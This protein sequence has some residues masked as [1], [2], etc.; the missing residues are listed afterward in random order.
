MLV[1]GIETSCDETGVALYDTARAGDTLLPSLR[2][3]NSPPLSWSPPPRSW[4]TWTSPRACACLRA[5]RCRASPSPRT[6]RRSPATT[7][8][9][10]ARLARALA[11]A[12]R[13]SSA[14]RTWSGSR[15]R[16]RSRL[17][18][19]AGCRSRSRIRRRRLG[20]RSW[21]LGGWLCARWRAWRPRGGR[22]LGAREGRRDEGGGVV[23]ATAARA[24]TPPSPPSPPPSSYDP[25]A[26]VLLYTPAGSPRPPAHLHPAT[27]RAADASAAAID[28]W[29]G[30]P[31]TAA[32]PVPD[33]LRP[34]SVA[35]VG[36][37]AAQISW[38][39]GFNQVGTKASGGVG[40]GGAAPVCAAAG[41][42][43]AL[44]LP[45]S[46]RSSSWTRSRLPQ[47]RARR[48]LRGKGVVGRPAQGPRPLQGVADGA[49]APAGG[50]RR[51]T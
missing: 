42:R 16:P 38:E 47:R 45:R 24:L 6:W 40:W 22:A 28:E 5:L 17:R 30:A 10:T 9:C 7:A 51:A 15:S 19:T 39:D 33:D 43:R 20:T 35:A 37:Y 31:A 14:S 21:N 13:P 44:T 11:P 41:T 3:S 34:A 23:G 27:V 26:N 48:R 4:P 25:E 49:W 46:R 1:L 50:A 18:A 32:A 2:P 36:N 29:T 12:F 8:P